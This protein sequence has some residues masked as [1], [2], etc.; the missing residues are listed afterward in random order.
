METEAL[1]LLD[2][3]LSIGRGNL[4]ICRETIKYIADTAQEGISLGLAVYGEDIGVICDYGEDRAVLKEKAGLIEL[5]DRDS[6]LTD[7]LTEELLYWRKADLADRCIIL[8]TDGEGKAPV[9]HAR[10]ELYYLLQEL[11]YPVYV[12]DLV[13]QEDVSLMNLSA[14]STISGGELLYSEFEDSDAGVEQK[15]GDELLF[16]INTRYSLPERLS[17]VKTGETEIYRAEDNAD[18]EALEGTESPV[19]KETK[20]EADMDSSSAENMFQEILEYEHLNEISYSDNQIALRGETV[21]SPPVSLTVLGGC[22]FLVAAI[23]IINL[24]CMRK[25]RKS[26]GSRRRRENRPTKPVYEETGE[27]T[28]CLS[29]GYGDMGETELLF[30]QEAGTGPLQG[31]FYYEGLQ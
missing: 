4:A 19:E 16:L 11:D 17:Y 7:V 13:T 20:D 23:I 2:N 27:P 9:R 5:A 15:L 8:F 6:C 28:V 21:S 29:E 24:F 12:V 10:E 31:G 14:I 25:K 22:F 26:A 30:S 3:S 18:Q 1:L